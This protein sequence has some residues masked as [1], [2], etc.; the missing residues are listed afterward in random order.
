MN[1]FEKSTGRI[2]FVEGGGLEY[3]ITYEPGDIVV[4]DAIKEEAI[5]YEGAAS[6][7]T[8]EDFSF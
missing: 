6:E 4:P 2:V 1:Y 5:D 8:V 3:E 7:G